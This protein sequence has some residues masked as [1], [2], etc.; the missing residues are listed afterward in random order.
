MSTMTV[1]TPILIL[2]NYIKDNMTRIP[3][4]I[5]MDNLHKQVSGTP[6]TFWDRAAGL[7]SRVGKFKSKHFIKN[8]RYAD[9]E[10]NERSFI[11]NCLDEL[12]KRKYYYIGKKGLPLKK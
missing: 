4:N 11:D 9:M 1:A 6:L 2:K 10:G 3:T 8:P 12:I 5:E 7:M